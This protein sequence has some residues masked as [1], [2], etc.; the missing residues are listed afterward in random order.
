MVHCALAKKDFA[1]VLLCSVS[2]NKNKPLKILAGIFLCQQVDP[3]RAIKAM[4]PF[5]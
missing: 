5:I 2:R 3:Y 4:A 1:T